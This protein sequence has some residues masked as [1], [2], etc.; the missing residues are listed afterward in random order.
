M[1]F[2]NGDIYEGDFVKGIKSGYG[3]FKGKDGSIYYEGDWHEDLM[4]GKG[5]CFYMQGKEK[6]IGDFKKGKKDGY[7]QYFYSNGDVYKGEFIEN[8]KHGLGE[9]MY[10]ETDYVFVGQF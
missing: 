2:S 8:I 6:F 5:V 9:Y 3:K 4:H 7:G 1:I 10:K